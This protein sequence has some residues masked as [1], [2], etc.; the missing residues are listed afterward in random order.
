MSPGNRLPFSTAS[1][2]DFRN[3]GFIVRA[4]QCLTIGSNQ[5]SSPIDAVPGTSRVTT[6]HRQSLMLYRRR[7]TPD[8]LRDLR[9]YR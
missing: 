3:T 7:D 4:Q 9:F 8:N 6:P 2:H 1:G 5:R